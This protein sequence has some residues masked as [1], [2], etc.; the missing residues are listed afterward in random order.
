VYVVVYAWSSFAKPA[1]LSELPEFDALSIDLP[2]SCDEGIVSMMGCEFSRHSELTKL[3][4]A[5][6][7][8]KR[9]D[10]ERQYHYHY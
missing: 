1:L 3:L 8:N 10:T 7:A 5:F 6:S 2:G 4:L 9:K